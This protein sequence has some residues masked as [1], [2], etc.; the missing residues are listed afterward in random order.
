[1]EFNAEEVALDTV[2][3]PEAWIV[4]EAEVLGVEVV[5]AEV[6]GV[7]VLGVEVLGP[8]DEVADVAVLD[9]GRVVVT[10]VL[11]GVA[12]EADEPGVVVEQ[13]S[14]GTTLYPDGTT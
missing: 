2:G 3:V 4:L 14:S 13:C 9:T 12:L 11:D 10:N 6:F 7:E 1:M 8:Y 5:G